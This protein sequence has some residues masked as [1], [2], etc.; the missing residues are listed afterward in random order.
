MI[1]YSQS[2]HTFNLPDGREA[3]A[4]YAGNG[5]WKND[6]EAQDVHDHGPLPQGTYTMSPQ[7]RYPHLGPAIYLTPDPANQMFGRSRFYIHGLDPQFLSDSSD[8][9]IC[10]GPGIR[11]V[12]DGY[13]GKGEN[14]LT[15]SK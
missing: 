2:L 15:V 11:Q 7:K 13:I 10:A 9:C 1:S 14:I 6:P 8:G 4:F 12:I 3:V 5:K